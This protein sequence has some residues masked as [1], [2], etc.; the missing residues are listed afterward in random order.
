[1]TEAFCDRPASGADMDACDLFLVVARDPLPL[2]D[3]DLE[4]AAVRVALHAPHSASALDPHRH[5]EHSVLRAIAIAAQHVHERGDELDAVSVLASVVGADR[6][7]AGEAWLWW[8]LGDPYRVDLA[9][10]LQLRNLAWW[11][12]QREA[13]L[14]AAIACE[15]MDLRALT[16]ALADVHSQATRAV[17]KTGKA[18]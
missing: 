8:E 5:M 6:A 9:T 18:A 16:A 11:R 2:V 1:M 17:A 4:A 7:A 14:R 15:R 13:C 12:A 10:V 3:H